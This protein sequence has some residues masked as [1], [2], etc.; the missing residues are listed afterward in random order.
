MRDYRTR[1]NNG[2]VRDCNS[3]QNTHPCADP[4]V[5][6]DSNGRCDARLF[7]NSKITKCSMV[8]IR[9]EASWRDDRVA[10]NDNAVANI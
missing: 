3:A 9:Y 6:A 7:V 4:H 10:S 1:A 2:S 5:G 8:M